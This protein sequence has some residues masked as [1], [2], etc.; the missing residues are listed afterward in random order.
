MNATQAVTRTSVSK[1]YEVSGVKGMHSKA[2]RKAFKTAKARNNW[3]IKNFDD[4]GELT[5]RIV[6]IY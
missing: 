5:F 6:N 3:V 1:N 4:I 2:F